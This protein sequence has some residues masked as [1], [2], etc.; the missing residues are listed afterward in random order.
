[1]HQTES[2][3]LDSPEPVEDE[4]RLVSRTKTMT[5]PRYRTRFVRLYAGQY[6]P[7]GIES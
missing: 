7:D 6:L 2:V 1:M 5:E 3:F 4:P